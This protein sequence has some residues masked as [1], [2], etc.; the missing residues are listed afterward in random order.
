MST[1]IVGPKSGSGTEPPPVESASAQA[2][3]PATGSGVQ[4][5]QTR[6]GAASGS[7]IAAVTTVDSPGASSGGSALMARMRTVVTSDGG[8]NC[9]MPQLATAAPNVASAASAAPRRRIR[10]PPSRRGSG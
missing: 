3:A 2:E 9:G 4:T 10:T 8:S 5:L 1:V 7:K 6:N